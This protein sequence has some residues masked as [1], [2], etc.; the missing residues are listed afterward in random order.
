MTVPAD[1]DARSPRLYRRLEELTYPF[2]DQTIT[3]THC[4]R[5]CFKGQNVNLSQ[6][7]R[8]RTWA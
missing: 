4:G 3:V 8:G 2:H 5:I 7:L 6:V 1:V